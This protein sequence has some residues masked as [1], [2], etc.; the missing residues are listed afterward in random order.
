MKK[1]EKYNHRQ[2]AMKS[3]HLT[4]RTQKITD[5]LSK[6]PF[7]VR[8]ITVALVSLSYQLPT[9]ASLPFFTGD[10]A[11]DNNQSILIAQSSSAAGGGTDSGSSAAGGAGVGSN[12]SASGSGGMDSGS[13]PGKPIPE[14]SGT[15]ALILLF[16]GVGLLRAWNKYKQSHPSNQE[17]FDDRGEE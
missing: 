3:M 13:G 10:S 15:G 8:T 4:S 17:T 2:F 6:R 14:P 1:K 16:A 5:K 11:L 12:T 7:V 9:Q